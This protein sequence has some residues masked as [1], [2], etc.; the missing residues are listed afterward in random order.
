MNNPR[1]LYAKYTILK[2][3]ELIED[4]AFVLLPDK[5]PAA[6]AA[7]L[8]YAA[9]TENRQLRADLMAWEAQLV[10]RDIDEA[11]GKEGEQGE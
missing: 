8:T 3:G 9:H 4:R 7:L 2:D 6:R 5:D 10:E 11:F 1:G